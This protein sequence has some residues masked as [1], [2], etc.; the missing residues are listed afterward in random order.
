MACLLLPLVLPS[1]HVHDN[2][3]PATPIYSPTS[4]DYSP[5]MSPDHVDT[6]NSE[7]ITPTAS[8]DG[9]IST[10]D[11][12]MFDM[13]NSDSDQELEGEAETISL[14]GDFLNRGKLPV[15]KHGLYV[16]P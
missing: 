12:D 8:S 10:R 2:Y 11:C 9:V 13:V 7:N 1:V 6:D 15:K 16:F 14:V 3:R 5:N 4:P